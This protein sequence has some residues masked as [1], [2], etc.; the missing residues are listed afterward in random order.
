MKRVLF[1]ALC[2]CVAVLG[3]SQ[4]KVIAHR[5]YWKTDGSA[6][7]S[8][9]SLV[10]ADSIKVFGSEFDVWLTSDDRIVVNHDKVFKGVD[11]ETSTFDEI[12]KIRLDNGE[13]VP[14]LDEYLAKAAQLPDTRLILE[15]KSLTDLTREDKAAEM[16]VAD[17]RKYGLLDR[18]D[19][20]CFSINACIQFKKLCPVGVK[21]YYL[22]GDLPPK[23]IAKLGLAGVDYS[24]KALRKHPEWIQQAHD[25]GLEVNV[26]TVDKEEDIKYFL[27]Q[28]VDY[29]TTNHPEEAQKLI[30][31]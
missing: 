29:I 18:T 5:G 14:T 24:M 15:L 6:Q 7:N 10:K 22:D 26:W 28:G 11:F 17:L 19:I 23:K 16:I 1:S 3:F 13:V 8:I 27:E 31:K 4:A 21:I 20:I 25:L 12:R 30:S 9:R 2:L